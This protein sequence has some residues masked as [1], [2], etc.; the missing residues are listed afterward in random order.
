MSHHLWRSSVCEVQNSLKGGIQVILS[1]HGTQPHPHDENRLSFLLNSQLCAPALRPPCHLL[2]EGVLGE[3]TQPSAVVSSQ[4]IKGQIWS[5]KLWGTRAVRG[6]CTAL[7]RSLC[8]I[9]RGSSAPFRLVPRVPVLHGEGLAMVS[10]PAPP[11]PE[12]KR[13]HESSISDAGARKISRGL[14]PI[15]VFTDAMFSEP[16]ILNNNKYWKY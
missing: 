14:V 4:R 7:L 8:V 6:A 2:M 5:Q 13:K 9:L 1:T 12:E 11:V 15:S 10:I 3:L 16:R